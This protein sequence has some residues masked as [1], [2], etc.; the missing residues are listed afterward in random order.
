MLM[1]NKQVDVNSNA[2]DGLDIDFFKSIQQTSLVDVLLE[3][4]EVDLQRLILTHD[5]TPQV[6]NF[7][8]WVLFKSGKADGFL[9][10]EWVIL[11]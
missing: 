10:D 7:I 6:Q 5:W 1:V 4:M 3:W 11:E 2:V 8:H 9:E